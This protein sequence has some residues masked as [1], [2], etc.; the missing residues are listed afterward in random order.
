MLALIVNNP[1][2]NNDGYGIDGLNLTGTYNFIN[3]LSSVTLTG[4]SVDSVSA[5]VESL[6]R[7]TIAPRA[8]VYVK[9]ENGD[10][11]DLWLSANLP[12]GTAL[13]QLLTSK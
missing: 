2:T 12:A 3:N 8:A 5:T 13:Y 6:A 1:E 10:G 11:S 4:P 9:V 7:P